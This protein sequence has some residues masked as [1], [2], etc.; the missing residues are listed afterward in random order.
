MI[1]SKEV[2]QEEMEKLLQSKEVNLEIKIVS[3]KDKGACLDTDMNNNVKEVVKILVS[4]VN[5]I[6][7]S[8]NLL[9]EQ[10]CTTEEEVKNV[11]DHLTIQTL[12]DFIEN[13]ENHQEEE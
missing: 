2:S 4:T 3:Y 5:M 11:L 1:K 12:F 7:Q 13:R 6:K 10:I 9:V 8:A